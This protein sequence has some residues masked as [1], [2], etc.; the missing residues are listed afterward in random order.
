MG[1]RGADEPDHGAL[2]CLTDCTDINS[3]RLNKDVLMTATHEM[4]P[5]TQ[6]E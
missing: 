6:E 4:T 1:S 3:S 5:P 2:T